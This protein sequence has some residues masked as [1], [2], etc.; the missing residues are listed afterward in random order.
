MNKLTF[1]LKLFRVLIILTFSYC[2]INGQTFNV[3]DTLNSTITY[4]NIH[5]TVLPLV[6]KGFFNF[7]IDIDFDNINDIRF[8]RDHSSSP[9][10]GS[11]T[12]SV[13]SLNTVQYV[14]QS[15]SS[16]ADT[17]SSGTVIDNLLNWNNNYNGTCFYYYFSSNIPPPWGLP[18][19]SHGICTNPN[20]YIGFRK[21]NTLDTL[22]GWFYLDLLNP[23]KIKSYAVNKK[24]ST[25]ISNQT[26]TV[27]NI[28]VFPNPTSDFIDIINNSNYFNKFQLSIINSTGQVVLKTN[29]EL[30]NK[31]SID[32]RNYKDGV[33]IIVLKNENEQ[34]F[35]K[36]VV[37]RL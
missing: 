36:F 32:I 14:I 33:Y 22:Y 29:I 34:C 19:T 7:D 20:T 18:S 16:D 6:A 12:F 21:I 5:D 10:F 35:S 9:S 17:L 23:Y 26:L 3:G 28:N 11:E 15:S 25:N 2:N 8:H 4:V 31:Y 13:L 24:F 1:N 27:N 37:N 30:E